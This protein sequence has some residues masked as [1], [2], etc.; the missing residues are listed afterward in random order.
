[1]KL[2]I[3]RQLNANSSS[4][5]SVIIAERQNFNIL[6]LSGV[7]RGL[8][9]LSGQNNVKDLQHWY[10]LLLRYECRE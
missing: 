9:S 2:A 1:M 5:E 4:M 8:E 3:Y 7:Y 6:T 10:L